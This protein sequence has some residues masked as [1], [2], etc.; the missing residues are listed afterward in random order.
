MPI[1]QPQAGAQGGPSFDNNLSPS[2]NFQGNVTRPYSSIATIQEI[3][4]SGEINA[5]CTAL[6]DYLFVPVRDVFDGAPDKPKVEPL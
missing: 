6:L 3:Q 1:S 4:T 5:T 2:P